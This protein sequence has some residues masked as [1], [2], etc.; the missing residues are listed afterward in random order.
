VSA[1]IWSQSSRTRDR[2]GQRGQYVVTDCVPI[3]V[4]VPTIGRPEQLR[5]CLRSILDGD[6]R[7]EEVL[8]VD[9][10]LNDGTERV[11]ADLPDLR[12]R[13]LRSAPPGISRAMNQGLE[14]VR[15]DWVLVT[16]DDCTVDGA[17]VR[18]AA[19]L[20][21]D[22]RPST[23]L[24]GRVLPVGDPRAVP[25]TKTDLEPHDYT[26]ERARA[27]LYPNNMLLPARDVL[28]IGG[29]D[30]MFTQAAEDNDLCYRWL[31][32]GRRLEYRPELVVHHH[33]WR[34]RRQLVALCARYWYGTG[35]FYGKHMRLGDVA[36]LSHLADEL[37]PLPRAYVRRIV[38]GRPQW[39]E[40]YPDGMLRGFPAGLWNGWR[41]ARVRRR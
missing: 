26:G 18:T 12:A 24:T 8:V 37:R 2:C 36:V 4:L 13:V 15:H 9:Q 29:F 35:Q 30:E 40:Y 17:W 27:V 6:R 5:S 41:S 23:I 1:G 31:K 19:S 3:T 25:S 16:H 7:P 28:E 39:P 20:S 32:A 34:T 11:V 14:H 21:A 22:A 38:R 10:T 33:D